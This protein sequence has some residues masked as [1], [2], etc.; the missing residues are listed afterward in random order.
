MHQKT[1]HE[2]TG[3]RNVNVPGNRAQTGHETKL[4]QYVKRERETVGDRTKNAAGDG[5]RPE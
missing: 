4:K 3:K 5:E 1:E 2:C